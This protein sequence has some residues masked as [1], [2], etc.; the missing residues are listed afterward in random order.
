MEGL[1]TWKQ[2]CVD[3][4]SL[5]AFSDGVWAI[6]LPTVGVHVAVVEEC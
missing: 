2:R 1:G 5:T 6:R 4:D 3:N